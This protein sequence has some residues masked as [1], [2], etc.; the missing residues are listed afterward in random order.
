MR[1]KYYCHYSTFAADY[2]PTMTESEMAEY[3]T[4]IN[5]PTNDW[6]IYYWA[7]GM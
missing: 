1:T 3:D 6:E 2:L 7:T 4:L 5:K